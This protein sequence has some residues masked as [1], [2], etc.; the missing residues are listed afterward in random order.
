MGKKKWCW[1]L[2]VLGIAGIAATCWVHY[3]APE[4]SV[5]QQVDS[6][7][8]PVAS[9]SVH[10]MAGVEASPIEAQREPAPE[11]GGSLSVSGTL[12]G[13][14]PAAGR[15][16]FL[17]FSGDGYLGRS[18]V[19]KLD[20]RGHGELRRLVPG[21]YRVYSVFSENVG[22]ADARVE[23][24]KTTHVDVVIAVE[25]L[26]RGRVVD[27]AGEPIAGARVVGINRN[28][29]VRTE[30]FFSVTDAVGAFEVAVGASPC[31]LFALAGGYSE[32]A[33]VELGTTDSLNRPVELVCSRGGA[34][35][36][37]KLYSHG[38]ASI[39]GAVIVVLRK[40]QTGL[41]VEVR[42]QVV[43]KEE[44]QNRVLGLW[45]GE[46][47]VRAMGHGFIGTESRSLH[48][49][50][51]G[52][53]LVV[54]E[55]LPG[56]AVSG[57]VCDRMGTRIAGATIASCNQDWDGLSCKSDANGS[58][59]LL[60]VSPGMHVVHAHHADTGKGRKEIG[61]G[62]LALGGVEICL[63]DVASMVGVVV[64]EGGLAIS[65]VSVRGVAQG[66]KSVGFACQTDSAGRFSLASMPERGLSSLWVYHE[67][68]DQKMLMRG[69][70]EQAALRIVL[71]RREERE[72]AITGTV[73]D[74]LGNPIAGVVAWAMR[75]NGK[76]G[77]SSTTREDGQFEIVARLGQYKVSV[78]E[79]EYVRPEMVTVDLGLGSH[80]DIGRLVL[81]K[82]AKVVVRFSGVAPVEDLPGA[83]YWRLS[84]LGGRT[85]CCLQRVGALYESQQ[86]A[87]GGYSLER[88]SG[89]QWVFV[90]SIT[91]GS[92]VDV[93]VV[94]PN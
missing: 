77:T 92:G 51:G 73:V 10:Q 58:F 80:A 21:D 53:E 42:K 55:A 61:V 47:I 84:D 74:E 68:Y 13:G 83:G 59:R 22:W 50:R 62:T 3:G 63:D 24:G 54:L 32:S 11:S 76:D 52:D 16:L 36:N 23:P 79:K 85:V 41:H 8:P 46:Y 91:I 2:G 57:S 37:V 70:L 15:S 72:Q 65:G 27:D 75:V 71:V 4:V 88:R 87:N 67:D 93:E 56:V 66:Q 78:L 6:G 81:T 20:D 39:D 7:V 12:E 17:G 44:A 49:D 43:A 64:D 19:I 14:A 60:R 89:K 35:L 38:G 45:P 40:M 94:L 29:P 82:G 9:S 26:V 1:V 28:D 5:G 86:L 18:G 30:E 48:L 90:R 69:E 33:L 25:G 31:F 34:I